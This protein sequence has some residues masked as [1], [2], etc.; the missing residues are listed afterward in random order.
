METIS[1]V[2][3]VIILIV[4]IFNLRAVIFLIFILMPPSMVLQE[5]RIRKLK[6]QLDE[7]WQRQWQDSYDKE[8]AIKE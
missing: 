2:E 4:D 1:N 8:I 3:E 5:I 7:I 6:K